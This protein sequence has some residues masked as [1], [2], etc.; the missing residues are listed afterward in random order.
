VKPQ[1]A[2]FE[3]FGSRGVAVLERA[4]DA[5]TEAG[6]IVILDAKRGDIGSTMEAYAEAF[7][8]KDAPSPPDALTVSPYLGYGSL[9]PAIDLAGDTGRGVFVLA[10]TSNPEGPSVQHAERD[11]VSVA[12]A[13]VEGAAADNAEAAARGSMGHVGLVV[14]AT[15]GT[16]LEDLGID[17]AASAAPILAPGLG[18]QGATPADLARTFGAALPHVLANSSR[19]I[20]SAGPSV[21]ALRDAVHR[22]A[23]LLR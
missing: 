14:G 16:A 6:T 13:I 23:D 18:A 10:L 7:L 2:F 21:S 12:R 19:A 9:R 8:G 5:F 11:G 20:L 17:L 3:V 22:E 15:I 1:S 4:V